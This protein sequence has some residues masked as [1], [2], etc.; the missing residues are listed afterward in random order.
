MLSQTIK[1]HPLKISFSK[2][3]SKVL[4]KYSNQKQQQNMWC[5]AAVSVSLKKFYNSI[6]IITQCK[7]ADW[8]FGQTDCCS[9][10]SSTRCNKG[11]QRLEQRR[12]IRVRE[13]GV[14]VLQCLRLPL[15]WCWPCMLISA[16][17]IRNPLCKERGK[18]RLSCRHATFCRVMCHLE[19]T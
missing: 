6:S 16:Y 3:Q 4:E 19:M 2:K 13:A 5:W 7:M 11:V 18:R 9:Y 15:G 10:G 1:T 14:V 17:L 12:V 8:K